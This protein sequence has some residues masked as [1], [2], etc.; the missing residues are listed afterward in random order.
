MA[1]SNAARS[2]ALFTIKP[3]TSISTLAASGARV[4]RDFRG[5]NTYT[6]GKR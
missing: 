3:A 6:G 5:Y 2:A 4:I 1:L